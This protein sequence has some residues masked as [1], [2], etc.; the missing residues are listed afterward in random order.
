MEEN[1]D[2]LDSKEKKRLY[3]KEYSKVYREKN[4]EYLA[5]QKKKYAEEHPEECKRISEKWYA[6]N[7]EYAIMK[8][9]VYYQEHKEQQL[10]KSQEYC[11][12]NREK[13]NSWKYTYIKKN[14]EKYNMFAHRR[15][16]LL[17]ANG[18][19]KI[20]DTD[21][22]RKINL[23]Q[24]KCFWCGSKLTAYDV[25]HVIPLIRGGQHSIGNI[26]ISCPS[27]N[28]RKSAKLPVVF[29]LEN[30]IKF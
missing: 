3:M 12:N 9:R 18:V 26:V 16:F 30:N 5:L 19:F 4:K 21:I 20:T 15:R 17:N 27:C 10:K 6:E 14:K 28:R 22:I 29:K 13:S 1:I 8:S 7:K 23:Q 11:E 25:D 24:S 2:I